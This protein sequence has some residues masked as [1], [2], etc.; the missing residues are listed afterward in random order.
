MAVRGPAFPSGARAAPGTPRGSSVGGYNWQS[1]PRRRAVAGREP[2]HSKVMVVPIERSELIR[3]LRRV[4]GPEGVVSAPSELAVYDCDALTIER[5][6]PDAVVF[7][8][9]ADEVAAVVRACRA[10]GAPIVPR[11][12][13]TSLAGGCVAIHGGVIVMLTRMNRVRAVDLVDRVAEVEAGVANLQLARAVAGTGFHYA[14]DPSSQGA[15]TIG[16]NVA[17]NAGGP[18]TLKYGVT[19]NHV[20]G[21]EIVLADGS[22]VQL[23]PVEHPGRLDLLGA[24][25]GSE[26]TLGIVTRVWVRLTPNPEDYRALRAM[27]DTLENASQAVSRI[28]AAGI[29]PSALEL[30]DRGILDAV[31]AAF[32]FGFPADAGAVLVIEID[33]PA[34][35]LERQQEAILDICRQ[36]GAREILQARDA[37]ERELLWKCRKLAVGAT[38]RLSPSYLIQD[39]VVPRTKLP[40]VIRRIAQIGAKHAVR[41]VNV[42]HAGDGNVHP[43]LLF[44]ERDR[45][46]V[47]RAWAAGREVLEE[48][49]ALG[50]SITAEHGVG[51]EKIALMDRLFAPADLDAMRRVREAFDP[52][53][54]LNPGKVLPPAPPQLPSDSRDGA[55]PPP[56]ET[57]ASPGPPRAV[58]SSADS[59]AALPIERFDQPRSEREVAGLIAEAAAVR[60]PV[61]PIGGGTALGFGPWPARPGWGVSLAEMNAVVEYEPED[62]T[63]T[64]GAGMTIARLAD[65]LA[66][67]RQRLP[68]DALDPARAT[69]GG[70]AATNLF[71]PRR[72]GFGTM[73]DYVLG[74]RAIDGRGTAFSAGGRVVKNAAGYHLCRLL[75]GSLGSLGVITQAT[76]LVRPMAETTA[77]AVLDLDDLSAAKRLLDAVRRAPLAPVALEWL[78][79]SAWSDVPSLPPLSRPLA[80]RVLVAFEGIEAEIDGLAGHVER[81]AS[82]ARLAPTCVLR[83]AAADALLRRL[84]E[85]PA[86]LLACVRPGRLVDLVARLGES[87]PNAA[88]QCHAG[89]GFVRIAPDHVESGGLRALVGRLR[90]LVEAAGGHLVVLDAPREE[91][92]SLEEVWGSRGA[93]ERIERAI[94][95]RFDPQGILNPGRL[96]AA[97]SAAGTGSTSSQR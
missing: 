23:G 93:G 44:D 91:A 59:A 36:C 47:G 64:V 74:L 55:E 17:T 43:I 88:F 32:H 72:L 1:R 96:L 69:V 9:S 40:Q 70:V 94:Q 95:R 85:A 46:Q 53:G 34:A 90:P 39:G 29:I 76:L 35:G 81:L 78:I 4:L 86:A 92:L 50:G 28:I 52:S 83:G 5:R 30:M 75:V 42:A 45:A 20:L 38:G 54:V 97:E 41:I 80:S 58:Q 18:H 56:G 12:A 13:G 63:I 7:P 2:S 48:C 79:G 3:D 51:L 8:R 57:E 11:G 87:V 82:E 22:I 68:V 73:R 21:V 16:G 24:I 37:A 89:N 66:E 25:T 84:A 14:P 77:V 60:A 62:M 65:V 15:S 61:Y 67:H 71:G 6:S 49:I 19:V 33:G 31:D 27:F 10:H 26:G